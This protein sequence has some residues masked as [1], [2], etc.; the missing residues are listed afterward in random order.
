[1]R[2]PQGNSTNSFNQLKKNHHKLKNVECMK[3]KANA[4]AGQ[5][6]PK[7]TEIPDAIVFFCFVFYDG[8]SSLCDSCIEFL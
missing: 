2:A 5:L 4:N 8:L 7:D 1:M 6:N 3:A